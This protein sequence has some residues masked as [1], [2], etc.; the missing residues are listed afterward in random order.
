MAS[1]A[2]RLVAAGDG[3]GEVMNNWQ[4][5]LAFDKMIT[6]TIIQ[7]IF[8]VLAVLVVLSGL[9]NLF[10]SGVE[11]FIVSLLWIVIGPIIVRIYC[12]I[13]IVLFRIHER[14]R[15]ISDNTRKA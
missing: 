6:P 5:W 12:E 13:I 11:G 7:I 14:L 2:V 15:E 9:F 4:E 1:R 8:W 3:K 10:R